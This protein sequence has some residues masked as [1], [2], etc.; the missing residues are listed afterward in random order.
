MFINKNRIYHKYRTSLYLN[1]GGG[2]SIVDGAIQA[3]CPNTITSFNADIVTGMVDVD[4]FSDGAISVN[5]NSGIK[6]TYLLIYSGS[7]IGK[8]Y[9]SKN[10]V[11]GDLITSGNISNKSM[12]S[13]KVNYS[14]YYMNVYSGDTVNTCCSNIKGIEYTSGDF[15][16]YGFMIVKINNDSLRYIRLYTKI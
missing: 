3:E 7:T 5:V 4:M 14:T 10:I 15:S 16:A 9:D 11:L 12:V 8:S 1:Q 13:V 2:I 6:N